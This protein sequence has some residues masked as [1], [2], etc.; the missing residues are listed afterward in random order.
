LCESDRSITSSISSKNSLGID[1]EED[2]TI[3]VRNVHP[4]SSIEEL[5]ELFN[6][7]GL[8]NKITFICDKYSGT[9]KG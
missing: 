8:V 3:I 2:K 6:K 9:F 4:D 7:F 1:N 5:E